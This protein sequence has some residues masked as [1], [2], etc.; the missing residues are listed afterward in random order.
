MDE[1]MYLMDVD[2]LDER[3]DDLEAKH[4]EIVEKM[5]DF[6][7]E[8]TDVESQVSSL[9]EQAYRLEGGLA[10]LEIEHN[11]HGG[12]LNEHANRIKELESQIT[13][14]DLS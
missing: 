10:M 5:D 7:S 11:D 3:V 8:V 4:E 13:E 1:K 2:D 9:D 12:W 6:E 14:D